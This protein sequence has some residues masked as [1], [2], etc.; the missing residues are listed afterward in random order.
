MRGG[1][2]CL[3]SLAI[4]GDQE[5]EEVGGQKASAQ[6]ATKAELRLMIGMSRVVGSKEERN[7]R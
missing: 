2:P 3:T 1:T 5:P 6:S 4:L 7:D